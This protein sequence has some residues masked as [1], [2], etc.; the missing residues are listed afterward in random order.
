MEVDAATIAVAACTEERRTCGVPLTMVRKTARQERPASVT[1]LRAASVR[2]RLGGVTRAAAGAADGAPE[3]V[4]VRIE[5]TGPAGSLAFAFGCG[6]RASGAT[7]E[8]GGCSGEA[9]RSAGSGGSTGGIVG[10]ATGV[11]VGALAFVVG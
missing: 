4:G 2:M 8:V 3:G 11:G 5:G 7:G 6:L 1:G 9:G 10:G